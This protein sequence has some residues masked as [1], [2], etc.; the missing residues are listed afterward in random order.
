MEDSTVDTFLALSFGTFMLTL[1]Q[2]TLS[3]PSWQNFTYLARGWALAWGR[4]TITTYLWVSGAAAVKHFSRSYAFLGG[5][6]YKARYA[7]WR[8]IIRYSATL[9]P[10][11]EVINIALD[12]GTIK[13]SGP[14]IEGA[15]HDRNGAGTARQDYRT[16]GGC[17]WCGPSCASL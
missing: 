17:I 9:V 7:F 6:L 5:P 3:A 13:K 10:P 11:E 15:S 4:Q 12:D 2:G 8:C 1:F 16:L 14:R